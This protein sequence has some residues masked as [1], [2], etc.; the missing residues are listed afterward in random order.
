MTERVLTLS[1]AAA[2]HKLPAAV[3]KEAGKR[4]TDFVNRASWETP[5]GE[6]LTL[7]NCHARI[8]LQPGTVPQES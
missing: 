7:C 3:P 2:S 6:E 5:L 1:V 4:G 8:W